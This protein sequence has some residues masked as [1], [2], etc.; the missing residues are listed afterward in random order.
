MKE[1]KIMHVTLVGSLV[2]LLLSAYKFIAG[3]LGNSSA[4][5]A[6][7]VHSLSDLISDVIV[8]VFVHI[9]GKP[10][11][12]DHNYGHGKY[13]TIATLAIGLILFAVGIGIFISNARGIIASVRGIPLPEPTWVALSAA[14]ISIVAKEG[15]YRYTVRYGKLMKSSAMTANAWHHRSDAFTSIAAFLGI[16]GA[17]LFGPK[18]A[19]LDPIAAVIVSG[20]I[21]KAAIDIA[22]PAF[23]E[24]TEKAVP[25]EDLIKIRDILTST[26]GVKTFH[27]LRTRKIGN[28]MA[29]DVHLKMSGDITLHEAHAIASD[30]EQ[31]LRS[32]INPDM[33]INIHME[34]IDKI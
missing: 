23:N 12:S 29:V 4:M 3:F 6:D 19:V 17:M 7:A 15:M 10:S 27:R 13:E 30:A 16:G 14:I 22:R 24:L 2:N 11:D 21:V 33:I 31:R 32:E 18:F 8:I 9:A 5:V 34:P 1:K 20:F 26:K 25:E 28:C